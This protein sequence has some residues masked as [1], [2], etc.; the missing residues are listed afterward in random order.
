MR[1]EPGLAGP[2]L[3]GA[4]RACYGCLLLCVPRRM[5]GV[6]IR[7]PVGGRTVNVT[8]V[9]GARHL[10][11]ATLTAA[12]LP[13]G[14]LAGIPPRTVLQAGAAVDT[15]HAAS[16]IA[17]ALAGR[18][19]RRAAWADALLETGFASFGIITARAHDRWKIMRIR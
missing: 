1:K 13:G 12:I 11:Q 5:I 7:D 4:V 15:T 19:L 10:V 2:D 17:L 3:L 8:R 9:L 16:M 14:D 18:P 6:V